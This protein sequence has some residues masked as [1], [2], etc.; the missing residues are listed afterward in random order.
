[1]GKLINQKQSNKKML[2][3]YSAAAVDGKNMAVD[4]NKL[5][6]ATTRF[7]FTDLLITIL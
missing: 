3:N 7:A 5:L 1:M 2:S 4:L 6:S